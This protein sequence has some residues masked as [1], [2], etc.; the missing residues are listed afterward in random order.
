M[1]DLTESLPTDISTKT[2]HQQFLR[3]STMKLNKRTP[4]ILASAL[5]MALSTSVFARVTTDNVEF[6]AREAAEGPRGADSERP[7]D[8]QRR[9]GRVTSDYDQ[10]AREAAEGP[11]GADRERPGDRQRRGG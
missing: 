2:L 6:A 11:R 8:R 3:R 1:H 9:G 5:L 10:L 4:T 7:G